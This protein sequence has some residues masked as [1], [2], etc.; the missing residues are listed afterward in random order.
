MATVDTT[1]TVAQASMETARALLDEA[2]P[3][4]E[5]TKATAAAI[6]VTAD[7]VSV[8]AQAAVT[9]AEAAATAASS[10]ATSAEAAATFAASASASAAQLTRATDEDVS[11]GAGDGYVSSGQIGIR[12]ATQRDM[13]EGAVTDRWGTPAGFKAALDDRFATMR[14][15]PLAEGYDWS[16]PWIDITGGVAGGLN[17]AG[18]LRAKLAA[19]AIIPAAPIEAAVGGRLAPSGSGWREL[20]AAGGYISGACDRDGRLL[21]GFT[22]KGRMVVALDDAAIIPSAVIASA[23]DPLLSTFFPTPDV[24]AFGDSMIQGNAAWGT[25]L[26][27]AVAAALGRPVEN[28]GV[29]GQTSTQVAGRQGGIPIAVTVSGDAIPSSGSVTCTS[30]APHV[31]H[32]VWSVV[33]TLA[34]VQGTLTIDGS[35][36]YTFSRIGSGDAVACPPGSIFVPSWA[37]DNRVKTLLIWSGRNNHAN[38]AT[39]IADILSMVDYLSTRQVRVLVLSVVNSVTEVAGSSAHTSILAL[40]GDLS[41]LFGDCYVDVRR[42]LIDSGLS[43]AGIPPTADDLTDMAADTIPRSL[44]VGSGDTLHLNGSANI[45]AGTF[46]AR[47]MRAKGW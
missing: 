33:G 11:A 29:G 4:L 10:A 46:I 39:V 38:R 3:L 25:T 9:S 5:E 36:V 2:A 24:V 37:S 18:E 17:L 41:R 22:Q 8:S 47:V 21:Y 28:R 13:I 30:V 7:Q 44:R 31:L 35:L 34:G 12:T 32:N 42:Y 45:V 43:E 1:E 20:A 27:A 40:N 15:R 16:W 19:D 6:D 26:P 14:A 23:T